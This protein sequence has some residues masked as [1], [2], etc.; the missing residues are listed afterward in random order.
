VRAL[1]GKGASLIAREP[2][3]GRASVYQVLK[4]AP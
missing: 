3:I 2:G 4:A 1:I